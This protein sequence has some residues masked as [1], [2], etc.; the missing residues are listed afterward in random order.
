MH[1]VRCRRGHGGR[2]SVQGGVCPEGG[3]CP[4]ACWDTPPCGQNSWHTLVKTLPFRNYVANGKNVHINVWTMLLRVLP[5]DL[6]QSM[7]EHDRRLCPAWHQFSRLCNSYWPIYGCCVIKN[8][9]ALEVLI[10]RHG[11]RIGN[12]YNE[13]FTALFS[14]PPPLPCSLFFTSK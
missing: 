5:H 14:D 8:T 9:K 6:W 3:V 1:T 11:L 13:T 10:T 4:S 12:S 2:G 7:V